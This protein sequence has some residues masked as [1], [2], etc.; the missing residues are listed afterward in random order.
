MLHEFL[1]PS[2]DGDKLY[3]KRKKGFTSKV[4]TLLVEKDKN[5]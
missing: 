2:K 5:I 3:T 4:I 1:C